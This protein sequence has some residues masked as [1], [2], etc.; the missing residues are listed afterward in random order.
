V[1]IFATAVLL[2]ALAGCGGGEDDVPAADA[3]EGMRV[4]TVATGLEVPWEIAFLPDRSALVT[5]RPGRIRVLE[6]DGELRDEPLAEVDVS[7]QGEGGLLGLALDPQYEDNGLV[8]LY[9]TTAEGM[10]LE[11][12][13]HADGSMSRE[14]ALV[15]DIEAGPVHDSGRIAFGPDDRLYVATG[16][17]GD[18][19][20]AQDDGS[21][22]GKFLRLTPEQY[23]GDGEARPEIFSKGHRNPQGFDWQDGR[24]ISTEHGP[25]GG[26]GPQGFDEVNEVRQGG[27]YGWPEAI[28]DDHEGFD[29]PLRVY[30]E[31]IAPS[32]ATFLEQGGAW[33]GDYLF[34]TL[35][36]EALYRLEMDGDRIAGEEKLLEGDYG[37]LRTVVEGPDGGVYVLTSNQDGRGS[38]SGDDDRIL[39]ITP[40]AAS[41]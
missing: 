11:R 18:G 26:D 39:R 32:G 10:R 19:E 24:L 36:G 25:S 2:L 17:A 23:R 7:A 34:A 14:A 6:A 16:D 40:P 22:N 35:R 8:Y 12:W 21:L 4:E 28:G 29:A 30:E 1:K 20:L 13:R 33:R 37:R 5:E 9:F 41:G 31:A 38:P 3:P 27:N 15:S